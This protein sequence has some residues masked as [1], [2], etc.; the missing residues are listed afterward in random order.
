MR[1]VT[2]TGLAAVVLAGAA[3]AGQAAAAPAGAM[4]AGCGGVQLGRYMVMFHTGP[5]EP[6]EMMMAGAMAERPAPAG[7][8]YRHVEVHVMS[9]RTC[10][11]VRGV[12][13]RLT[14]VTGASAGVR[15]RLMRMGEGADRHFGRDQVLRP[16]GQYQAVIQLGSGVAW[17]TPFRV[18]ARSTPAMHMH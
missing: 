11:P 1:L 15:A 2:R 18:P 10:G 4:A 13:P 12:V 3:V 16:G 14:L 9:P 17:F 7:M 8:V 6:E 5:P